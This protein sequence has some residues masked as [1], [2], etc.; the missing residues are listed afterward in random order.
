MIQCRCSWLAGGFPLEWSA[1]TDSFHSVLFHDLGSWSLLL[2]A[3]RKGKKKW[4]ILPLKAS[5]RKWQLSLLLSLHWWELVLW[6]HLITKA[7]GNACGFTAV[8]QKQSSTR[9]GA[10][11]IFGEQLNISAI[12][13]KLLGQ[14]LTAYTLNWDAWHFVNPRLAYIWDGRSELKEIPDDS[15][16]NCLPV[17]STWFFN[18]LLPEVCSQNFTC[19]SWSKMYWALLQTQVAF[20]ILYI[21]G[22]LL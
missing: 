15:W 7:A 1:Y 17:S 9:K 5:D 21:H 4:R 3:D 13:L 19:Q 10:A 6:P 8:N 22:P 11:W 14:Y 12:Q 16:K 2:I 20:F 18:P